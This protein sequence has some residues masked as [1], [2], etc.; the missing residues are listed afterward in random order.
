MLILYPKSHCKETPLSIA[1]L[2]NAPLTERAWNV[3]VHIQG[4]VKMFFIQ[5]KMAFVVFPLW[6]LTTARRKGSLTSELSYSW[7]IMWLPGRHINTTE[8]GCTCPKIFFSGAIS[9]GFLHTWYT[10]NMILRCWFY[11]TYI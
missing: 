5:F 4:I 8:H 1:L 2:K 7:N 6:G 10:K 11:E 9:L 3:A